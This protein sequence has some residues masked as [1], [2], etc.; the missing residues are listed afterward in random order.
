MTP[1]KKPFN[2]PED[3]ACNLF[4]YW[5]P[6][7]FLVEFLLHWQEVKSSSRAGS[8]DRIASKDG[9][10]REPSP[11]ASVSS[12]RSSRTSVGTDLTSF[13]KDPSQRQSLQLG[14]P[15][16]NQDKKTQMFHRIPPWRHFSR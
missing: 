14:K 12:T 11:S 5:S 6:F 13:E 1:F 9:P 8:K 3:E 7:G 16:S 2:L 4:L 10:L 15:S